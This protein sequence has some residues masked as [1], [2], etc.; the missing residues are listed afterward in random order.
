M[1]GCARPRIDREPVACSDRQRHDR[2]LA[3]GAIGVG[4]DAVGRMIAGPDRPPHHFGHCS[5]SGC[6]RFG[7]R[8]FSGRS[9]RWLFARRCGWLARSKREQA[10]GEH[11]AKSHCQSPGVVSPTA[12]GQQIRAPLNRD[13]LCSLNVVRPAA[14][15]AATGR[16]WPSR[17]GSRHV[18]WRDPNVPTPV[19][20]RL[21]Q[22]ISGCFR[23]CAA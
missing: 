22:R 13:G 9:G 4:L 23:P 1:L 12:W 7:D 8:R 20:S 21:R 5:A 11:E 18:G 2:G 17:S 16:T 3:G 14:G 6:G 19:F 10:G 15:K